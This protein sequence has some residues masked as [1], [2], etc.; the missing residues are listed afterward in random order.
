MDMDLTAD[1]ADLLA[2][3]CSLLPHVLVS[4]IK[5][6]LWNPQE[7]KDTTIKVIISKLILVLIIAVK[8]KVQGH[9]QV[10]HFCLGMTLRICQLLAL[11][12]ETWLNIG[13]N[14]L[15]ALCHFH[16]W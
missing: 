13:A 8:S 14:H 9:N 5:A 6:S 1:L 7:G 15:Q 2:V 10:N 3:G 11:M 4:H 16:P 12:P